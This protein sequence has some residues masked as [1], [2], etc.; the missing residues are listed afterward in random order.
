[1]VTTTA[2]ALVT[3]M[4]RR[5]GLE[6]SQS[7]VMRW[8]GLI[9]DDIDNVVIL[10]EEIRK[11]PQFTARF[12]G[13]EQRLRNGYSAIS[14][15]EYLQL[16]DDMRSI[17]RS[18][19]LPE[20]FYD[21]P[22]ELAGFI[23]NDVAPSEFEKRVIDGFIAA[24]EAPQEVKD[25]LREFYGVVD[26]DAALA[27]YYLDPEKALPAIQREF[28]SATI[29]SRATQTGFGRIDRTQ[30]EDLRA[31]G[32]TSQQALAGFSQAALEREITSANLG[33]DTTFTDQEVVDAQFSG[34]ASVIERIKKQREQRLAEFGGSS[35]RVT[36]AGVSTTRTTSGKDGP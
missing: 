28:E 25:A 7:T 15:D 19:G 12:P 4:L 11:S 16:E 24:R 35:G 1:M 34:D 20:T 10:E 18:A 22:E 9:S 32:V 30:A 21:S 13:L 3:E 6:Y 33:K 27:A 5:Y 8:V 29:A 36:G 26:S 23:A 17:V 14:V 2:T 31:Q